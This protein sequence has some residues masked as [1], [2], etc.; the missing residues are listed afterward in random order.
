[1]ILR[2]LVLAT[3]AVITLACSGCKSPQGATVEDKRAS[4]LEMRDETLNRLY[5]AKPGLREHIA[6][7]PGYAV[8]SNYG[9]KIFLAGGGNGY[10]V[11]HDNT[12]GTDTFM[13]MA[14]VNVGLGVGAKDFRAVFVFN[15][16][17]VMHTF[18]DKGWDFGADAEA[19]AKVNREGAEVGASKSVQDMEIYQITK[20]GVALQATV[21]G[22]KYWK[23]EKLAD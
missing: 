16:P 6:A 22:T 23:D 19:G 1:M 10:G 21:G 2:T 5:A 8:F 14:E 20:T 4:V 17:G 18:A 13:R 11:L 7:A 15:K 9:L 3:T 12:T